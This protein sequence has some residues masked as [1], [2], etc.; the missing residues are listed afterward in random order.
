M[1]HVRSRIGYVV[2]FVYNKLDGLSTDLGVRIYLRCHHVLQIV[3]ER[4]VFDGYLCFLF[5]KCFAI[6]FGM[7]RI[8]EFFIHVNNVI[9]G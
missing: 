8:G 7:N 5:E 2:H 3:D 1:G 6:V 4:R 9:E